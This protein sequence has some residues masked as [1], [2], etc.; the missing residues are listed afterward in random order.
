MTNCK[1]TSVSCTQI[2]FTRIGKIRNAKVRAKFF[3][4]LRPIQQKGR[5]VPISLQNKVDKEIHR[6][7]NEGRIVK[8]QKC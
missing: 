2:F 8:L 7:I 3:E 1:H 5:R 4:N 6:L